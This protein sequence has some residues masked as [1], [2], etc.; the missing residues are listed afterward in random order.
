MDAHTER[1]D[2]VICD[3]PA[4]A[5]VRREQGV[6]VKGYEKLVP[7]SGASGYA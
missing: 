3:P 2:I 1:H 5:K 7:F 4:F 6:A